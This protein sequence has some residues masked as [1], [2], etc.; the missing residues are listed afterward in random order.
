MLLSINLMD[1]SMK[2]S[3][4]ITSIRASGITVGGADEDE[5]PSCVAEVGAMEGGA[6][7]LISSQKTPPR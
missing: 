2:A 3:S 6:C 1:M 5:P 4:S 7:R